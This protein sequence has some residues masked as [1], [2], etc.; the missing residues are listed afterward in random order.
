VYTFLAPPVYFII[1]SWYEDVA[2]MF[3]IYDYLQNKVNLLCRMAF[4]LLNKMQKLVVI[5]LLGTLLK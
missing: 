2:A 1:L 4:E 3:A 5:E